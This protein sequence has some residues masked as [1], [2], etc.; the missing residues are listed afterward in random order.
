VGIGISL[1]ALLE[2]I[3]RQR[4]E[5]IQKRFRRFEGVYGELF[6]VLATHMIS[7][8]DTEGYV[9]EQEIALYY[10]YDFE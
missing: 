3:E 6:P 9:R 8:P 1:I 7:E 5:F 2:E 4:G 10:S